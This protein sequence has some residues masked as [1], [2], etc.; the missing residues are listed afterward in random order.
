MFEII[1]KIIFAIVIV[2]I[3]VGL[4]FTLGYTHGISPKNSTVVNGIMYD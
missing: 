2:A 1:E 3:F 4:A